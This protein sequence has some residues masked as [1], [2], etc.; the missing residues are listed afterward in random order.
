VIDLLVTRPLSGTFWRVPDGTNEITQAEVILEAAQIPAGKSALF[1]MDAAHAQEETAEAMAGSLDSATLQPSRETSRLR[2]GQYSMR[3]SRCSAR[4]RM[5]SRKS[6]AAGGLRNGPAGLSA[7]TA[8][9]SRTPSRPPS[10]A[11]R[12]SKYPVTGSARRTP[13]VRDTVYRE[14]HGQAW[15]GEGL[16]VLASLRNLAVE[17]IRLKK[18]RNIDREE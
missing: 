7:R 17:L 6:T 1:T 5:T 4:H 9:I 18:E 12:Y 2:R 16:Q 11:A 13:Y 15:A 14:D 10:S 3:S 8:S